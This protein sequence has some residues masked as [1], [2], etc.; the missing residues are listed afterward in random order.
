[1]T[2][3]KNPARVSARYKIVAMPT[4]PATQQMRHQV[5]GR[6]A[7]FWP[8]GDGTRVALNVNDPVDSFFI[9]FRDKPPAGARS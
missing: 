9:V 4:E 3:P 5:R 2:G 1:M 8:D 6:I 7:R